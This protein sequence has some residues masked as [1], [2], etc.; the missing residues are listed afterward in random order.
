MWVLLPGSLMAQTLPIDSSRLLIT[1]ITISGNER[2]RPAV[3]LRELT[4]SEGD[5]LLRERLWQQFSASRNNLLNTGLFHEATLSLQPASHCLCGTVHIE[6][7]ERWYIIPVPAISLY[8]RNFNVWWVEH[9]RDLRW[10]QWGLRFYYKNLS[11]HNDE[12][13]LTALTGFQ[14]QFALQYRLPQL[15]PE[16]RHLLRI[17]AAYSRSKRLAYGLQ[18]N[19]ELIFQ[20]IDHYQRTFFSANMDYQWRPAF[21]HRYMFT[22]GLRRYAITDTVATLNP[23]YAGD[24]ATVLF[25]PYVAFTYERDF[26]DVVAYPLKG[27]YQE[28]SL[29]RLGLG[30]SDNLSGW[31]MQFTASA[32]PCW[33][34]WYAAGLIR[35]RI[36][37][38]ADL[39]YLLQRGIGYG[40]DYVSG[41][42]YYAINGTAL[43]IAKF[44]LRRPLLEWQLPTS[45]NNVLT[46][47]ARLPFLIYTKAFVESG[48]V[49]QKPQAPGNELSNRL[50]LSAGL[51]ADI[52]LFYDTSLRLNYAINCKREHGLFVHYTTYF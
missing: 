49:W 30:F 51:G 21:N 11:G 36:S 13:R 5:T 35:M 3:I 32:Y 16:R 40:S 1:A 41:Y 22:I 28:L 45:P 39:P 24:S 52:V 33:R 19:R 18:D 2:T 47:G 4:F 37:V 26:R 14:Q 10:L 34:R 6:V 9:R 44:A 43:G 46:R 8:D 7:I 15:D 27:N 38:P 12:L 25:Y 42:E 48:Y 31:I 23:D 20:D 17:Y 50:L 29:M